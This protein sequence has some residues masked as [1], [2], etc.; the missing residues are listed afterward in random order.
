MHRFK[1]VFCLFLLTNYSLIFSLDLN[2]SISNTNPP[3]NPFI[4]AIMVEFQE[5]DNPKT[6]GNGLFLDTLDINMKVDSSLSRCNQFI[7]DRPPHNFQYFNSQIQAVSNYYNEISNDN[8][9]IQSQI[10]LNG[11][12]LENGYYKLSKEMELYSYS[13]IHL[14]DLFK[15][16]LELAKTDIESFLNLNPQ[17]NFD[18]IIFTVFHAGIGQDFSFPT[19]D[20]TVYDIKSA[21]IEPTMFGDIDYPQINGNNVSSGILL[22]ETQNMIF[23]SSIEDIFY[24]ESSYCDYQLGMTGTFSFLMGYALGLPPL[25]NTD[26][27]Q[28]GVGIFSL[29]DYGS[30]NGRGIIPALPSPWTRVIMDWDSEN[31]MTSSVASDNFSLIEINKDE[32][33]RFDISDNEYFLLENKINTIG[34]ELSLEDI[35]SDYNATNGDNIYQDSYS[36]WLDAIISSNDQHNIFEFQ[37]S[38]ITGVK[39]YNLGLPASGILVWHIKEPQGSINDGIN[40]D[41]FNKSVSIE[42]ADG[43]LDIGFESYALFSN[44]DPT[45]GTRWDFWYQENEA[46]H[47]ANDIEHKC[48]NSETFE[49]LDASYNV[50]CFNSGGIWLK[51]ETF[52]NFSNPS[53]NLNDNTKSFFS[54][55]IIDSISSSTKIKASYISSIPYYDLNLSYNKILGTAQDKIF[56]GLNDMSIKELNLIDFNL[57]DSFIEDYDESTLILTN[58]DNISNLY[59]SNAL[60]SYLDPNNNFIENSKEFWIGNFINNDNENEMIIIENNYFITD[61]FQFQ[62]EFTPSNGIS[63]ADIDK[64]GLDEIIYTDIDGQIVA[65]N[66]NGTL[67]NGFPFG[68]DYHGLVLSITEYESQELVLVCRNMSHIDIIDINTNV[69]SIP[70]LDLESDI[71]I[72]NDF[73]TDGLRFYNLN[74]ED[75]Y[76]NIG[77]IKYW[78]QRYNNHSHYPKSSYTHQLSSYPAKNKIITS[79]YNYPNPIT[80]GLTKFRFF[81][82]EPTDH[83]EINIYDILG[84]LIDSLVKSELIIYENNEIIWDTQNHKP[85]LYFAEI[86]SS[87]K[88]QDII[89]IVIGY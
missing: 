80:N 76:F 69:I 12:N 34:N 26:S 45:A 21:Y 22:P 78:Q 33:Y 3:E 18:D 79:F 56:Y 47:F 84:N 39:N 25:F 28:P 23:F 41:I 8:I 57:N 67:V 60:F 30:N 42:E 62:F 71:M 29:M 54:F 13:D 74:S 55:E 59:Y 31:N 19:F 81:V 52:D 63:V 9:N 37:D 48:F 89:K 36:N 17:I 20:P 75:S 38:V 11:N 32:I 73:L 70:S 61:N 43:V 6:S 2:S 46:Y 65:Y 64:D 49:L 88:Q 85:G 51:T 35:V 16:S 1:T 40:N 50:E 27:G 53:S 87:N 4:I 86:L 14:S 72:I 10:V 68:R 77:D 5:D 83:I 7:L 24:G 82:N 66:G 15:E 58:N 44:Q